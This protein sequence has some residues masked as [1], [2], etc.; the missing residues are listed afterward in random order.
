MG[1]PSAAA[2]VSMMGIELPS[3]AVARIVGYLLVYCLQT[4]ST[5]A[6][7]RNY[8]TETYLGRSNAT[9][10]SSCGLVHSRCAASNYIHTR[11]LGLLLGSVPA[12][13]TNK[14]WIFVFP[15]QMKTAAI[16]TLTRSVVHDYA[17]ERTC[18]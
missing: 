14:I 16:E 6:G 10:S 3:P 17:Y 9:R 4:V 7:L 18:I 15:E 2:K 8:E 5:H 12:T 1:K 13:P 11:C